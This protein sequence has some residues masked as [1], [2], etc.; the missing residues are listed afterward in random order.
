MYRSFL[1]I[2][3]IA[4]ATCLSRSMGQDVQEI[5][6]GG[7][8]EDESAWTVYQL[9][10]DNPAEYQ[11]NFTEAGPSAGEGGCLWVYGGTTQE[12]NVLFW[13]EVT[14]LGGAT[15]EISGAFMDLTGGALDQFWTDIDLSTEA[16]VD[17]VNYRPLNDAN[18]DIRV[19]MG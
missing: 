1:L 7:N 19:S 2:L 5:L 9:N 4:L 12:I 6:V 18:T 14:L 15:Y 3:F 16:P 8:M 11:F 10:S 13:Q 17:G